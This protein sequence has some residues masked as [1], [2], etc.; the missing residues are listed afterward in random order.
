MLYASNIIRSFYNLV[1]WQKKLFLKNGHL[2]GLS[3]YVLNNYTYLEFLRILSQVFQ[4]TYILK[5]SICLYLIVT[6]K[7]HCKVDTFFTLRNID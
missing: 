1:I 2:N 4:Q 5:A 7:I 6:V 3:I